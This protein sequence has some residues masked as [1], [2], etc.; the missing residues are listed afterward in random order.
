MLTCFND[1]PGQCNGARGGLAKAWAAAAD[2]QGGW[3]QRRGM[4][5]GCGVG[6]PGRV[7]KVGLGCGVLLQTSCL[8]VSVAGRG[9][10]L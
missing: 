8:M 7:M 4:E 1:V 6:R 3:L 2:E 10:L 9:R 5:A